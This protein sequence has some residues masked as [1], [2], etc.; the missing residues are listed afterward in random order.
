VLFHQ[1]KGTGW[2]YYMVTVLE[3]SR[4]TPKNGKPQHRHPYGAISDFMYPRRQQL[5][6]IGAN[7]WPIHLLS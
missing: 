1:L 6:L 4:S 3:L 2:K 5:F 7:L